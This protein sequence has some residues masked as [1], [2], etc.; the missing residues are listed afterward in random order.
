MWGW[1]IRGVSG[2]SAPGHEN[3][4][5]LQRSG[6]KAISQ[7]VSKEENELHAEDH[8]TV[9]PIVVCYALVIDQTATSP[10]VE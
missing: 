8:D 2:I 6:M 3:L 4:K 9:I 1:L 10:F 5:T 7:F